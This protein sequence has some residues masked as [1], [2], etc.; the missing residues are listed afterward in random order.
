[1]TMP[2]VTPSDD[3][4]ESWWS[5]TNGDLFLENYPGAW[6]KYQDEAGVPYWHHSDTD[7]WFYLVPTVSQMLPEVRPFPVAEPVQQHERV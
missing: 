2:V 1:M 3:N 4:G 6:S 5:C 7:E